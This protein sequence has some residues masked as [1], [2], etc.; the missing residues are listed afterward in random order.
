MFHEQCVT[1]GAIHVVGSGNGTEAWVGETA[2]QTQE[3][4]AAVTARSAANVAWIDE[5]FDTAIARGSEGVFLL[6]QAAPSSSAPFSAVRTKIVARA[7]AFGG[8]VI[9]AHGDGHVYT[10][11]PNYLGLTNVTFA[12]N[13]LAEIQSYQADYAGMLQSALQAE[14]VAWLVNAESAWVRALLHK[15]KALMHQGDVEMALLAVGKALDTSQQLDEPELL[16]ICLQQVCE[17]HIRIGRYRPVDQYLAQ[18]KGQVALLDRLDNR[19]AL[20]LT[21]RALG[22]VNIRLG[23]FDKAVHWLLLAVNTYRGL[24]DQ[25]AI[26]QTL[27]LLGEVSRLRGQ[28]RAAIPL[29][30]KA[31]AIVNGLDHRLSVMQ[32]RLNL[33]A[34]LIDMGSYDAAD[35]AVRQV[36]RVVEDFSKMAGWYDSSRVYVYQALA[37]L[38]RG[39]LESALRAANRAHRKAAMQ[40]SDAALGFAWYG[41]ARVLAGGL[42]EI[43]PLQI[44]GNIYN[45]SDCF[46]ES[47]RL[48]S[49]INGGG[50][51]SA[52]DQARTLW[53]WSAHE[54]A[55]HNVG[56]RPY[57]FSAR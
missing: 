55:I 40:E 5:V 56:T 51:A 44:D 39:D 6:M 53:A 24:E 35:R 32:V 31:L 7:Q 47:L 25:L 8:P 28:A 21:H 15:S 52:R 46:A 23:R 48:F 43:R 26:G 11:T 9:V 18:L 17:Q 49:T 50:V 16:T 2:S 30:R 37:H 36:A 33:A 22:E 14:R 38:G 19:P 41:L 12:W 45:A 13:G 29:Y 10:V 4:E 54:A 27:N 1:F 57:G 34:A 42:R 20:A 3:R